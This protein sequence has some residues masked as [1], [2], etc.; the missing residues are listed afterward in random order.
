[1]YVCVTGRTK[2]GPC[3][4]LLIMNA[5]GRR[6]R[7][8]PDSA[9][10][11]EMIRLT[12]DGTAE[13]VSPDQILRRERGQGNINFPRSADREQDWQPYRLVHTLTIYIYDV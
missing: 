10:S 6:N 8:E 5:A 3:T 13:P 7:A 9:W 4:E 2:L 12:R 11:M 1:M